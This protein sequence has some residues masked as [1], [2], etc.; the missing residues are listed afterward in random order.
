MWFHKINLDDL[1][2]L[3]E[4]KHK[5]HS[6]VVKIVLDMKII[7]A[8]LMQ[9]IVLKTITVIDEISKCLTC[10]TKNM[11]RCETAISTFVSI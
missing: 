11:K 6:C 7:W 3:I 2:D 9:K 10:V 1:P 4:S 5:M 8:V